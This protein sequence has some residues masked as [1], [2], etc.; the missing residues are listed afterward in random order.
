MITISIVEDLPEIRNGIAKIIAKEAD[1]GIVELYDNAETAVYDIVEK[2]PDIV[3]MDIN[4]PG[5]NGI[6]VC[7]KLKEFDNKTERLRVIDNKIKTLEN[8][9]KRQNDEFL[10]KRLNRSIPQLRKKRFLPK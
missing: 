2:Q 8:T 10:R 7:K 4:L 6:E 1:L 9:L 5:M 3:I